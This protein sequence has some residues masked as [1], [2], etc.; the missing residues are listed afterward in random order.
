M[1]APEDRARIAARYPQRRRSN[2]IIIAAAVLATVLGLVWLA[3]TSLFHA[4]P[5]IAGAVNWF[6][7]TSDDSAEAILTVQRNSVEVTGV[8]TVIAQAVTFERVGE[9]E[10]SIGAGQDLL[11]DHPIR[12]KTLKRATSVSVTQCRPT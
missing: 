6:S 9:I 4:S 10:V 3:W 12:I 5:A 1:I 7:I 8:C 11:S 2:P